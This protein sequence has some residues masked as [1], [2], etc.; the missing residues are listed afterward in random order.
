MSKKLISRVSF[1]ICF[2]I[3]FSCGI[4]FSN[5]QASQITIIL[6]GQQLVYDDSTGYPYYDS[7]GR[8]QVPLRATLEPLGAT[9]SVNS[10]K[11]SVIVV[12]DDT[13]IEVPFGKPYI[14]KNGQI[15]INDTI[16]S[17]KNNK[18]YLPIRIV[19][20][21]LGYSLTFNSKTN[22]LSI[23]NV[24][25]DSSNSIT[26]WHYNNYDAESIKK[27][28]TKKFPETKIF[29]T[30]TPDT[31][32]NYQKK[33]A[34]AYR[35]GTGMPDLFTLE[36]SFI[37]YFIDVDGL[38][39]NLGSEKYK[40]ADITSNMFPFTLDVAKD[41][42]GNL[43]GLSWCAYPG[44]IGYKRDIAKKY[45]G[46]DDPDKIS[47][48][49][50]SPENIIET[51]RTL[52]NNSKGTAKLF[53]GYEELFQIYRCAR[54]QPW[55]VDNKLTID[56]KMIEYLDLQKYLTKNK[57]SDSIRAWTPRWNMSISDKTTMCYSI[58]TWGIS[59]IIEPNDKSNVDKGRW[60][61][62]KAP[63]SYYWGATI[64]CMSA[65]SDNKDLSWQFIKYL[66]SDKNQLEEWAQNYGDFINNKE[67]VSKFKN[68]DTY[69]NKTINQNIF[70]VFEPIA[71]DI[72]G[73]LTTEDEDIINN[74]WLNEMELYLS[75]N[76]TKER[77][78]ADFRFKVFEDLPY[79][80][81][82]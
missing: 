22:T 81:I 34:A 13:I 24:R 41:D 50:S 30:V 27:V 2:F 19:L 54:S 1:L 35:S 33:L 64:L 17:V 59:N 38:C 10:K 82:F 40:A 79:I 28:L 75:D 57:Y 44:G 70:K 31:Q 45:L 36:S 32:L 6:N 72:K 42:E 65:T 80:D 4:T 11:N 16:S 55:I 39:E 62:A 20:E 9:V 67:L 8:M 69:I 3:V 51:S 71:N 56:S 37:K 58:P 78:L 14:Y 66:T 48:M 29:L 23:D 43:K 26:I 5:A 49:L 12:K 63:Y 68:D 47:N 15:L 77:T 18:T 73:S 76:K 25:T 21:A 53:P 46:T 52:Y 7:N 60:G 61:I 74:D